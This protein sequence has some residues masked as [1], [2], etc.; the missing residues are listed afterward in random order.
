MAI[1]WLLAA[2]AVLLQMLTNGRYGYF[3]D[4]FYFLA[5]G[6]HLAWGYVDFAP[7]VALLARVSR[8]L[9]GDSLH[10][11]RLLPALAQGAEILLTGLITCELGGGRFA[12]LLSCVSVLVA[13]VIL[14]NATRLSMNPFEPLF[15]MG[16]VYF[17]LLG[18]NRAQPK[19][20]LW[21][22]VLLGLGLENKHSTAFFLFSLTLGLLV[23]SDRRLLGSKWFWI[24]AFIAL[25]IFMPNLIWQYQHH[26]PTLEDLSNVKRTHKN[27]EVSPLPF[28]G[29]QIMMLSPASAPVSIAGLGFLLLHREGKRHPSLGMTYLVFLTVMM[30]LKGKDYYLAPIYP[31]LFAAG[32]VF[33]ETVTEAHA[34]MRWL[35]VALPAVVFAVGAVAVPLNV[36]ILPVEKVVPYMEALGVKMTRTEVHH[37]GPLPQHFGDE[38]GWPEMVAAVANIYNSMPPEE[39]AK[40]GILAGN[41]GEAGAIDFFGPRY[42]LPKSISAHQ[43]YYF[44]GPRQYTGESLVLLQWNLDSAQRWCQNVQEGPTLDPPYGMG[45]EHYTI[46]ICHAL[47]KPLAEAWPQL[48]VWN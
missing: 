17:L 19:L 18:M 39:R 1:A 6:D 32:G 7:L 8:L 41:Y 45:E 37:G 5:A 22:G 48:K 11:I 38:F 15:W 40:T 25:L 28:I 43:N 30:A 16:C 46:L 42:G 44:W 24:A 3:R 36:P 10:A 33:W 9:F 31:M 21:C 13:P 12:V 20:L 4:E 26:F 34:G 27:I 29:Q 14:G 47:K 23:T 2:V 35:R